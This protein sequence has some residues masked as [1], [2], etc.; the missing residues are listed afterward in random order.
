MLY[1]LVLQ[2]ASHSNRLSEAGKIVYPLEHKDNTTTGFYIRTFISQRENIVSDSQIIVG[3][4]SIFFF[5]TSIDF[6]ITSLI[7]SDINSSRKQINSLSTINRAI[8][9]L[10]QTDS[11]V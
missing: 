10:Q 3:K 11:N 1:H 7:P 2:G 5:F 4:I 9:A 8:C 6:L